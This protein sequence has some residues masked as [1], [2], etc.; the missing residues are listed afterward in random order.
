MKLYS[1][2][3]SAVMIVGAIE[4]VQRGVKGGGFARAGGA[5]HQEDAIKALDD[6]LEVLVVIF[7]EAHALNADADGVGTQNTK[8]DGLAVITGERA[9][10]E[11]NV[12][13]IDGELE[14]SHPGEALFGDVDAGHDFCRWMSGFF[15][16]R[17]MRSRSTH[18][19]SMR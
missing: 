16:R 2:G 9:D 19:P 13:L 17:G 11:V 12:V 15:M 5:G 10:A 7:L 6:S 4:L 1:T 14:C 3:S 18:S 8:H